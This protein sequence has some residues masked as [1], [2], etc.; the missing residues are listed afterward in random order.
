MATNNGI[1]IVYT[2]ITTTNVSTQAS[3][4]LL[5]TRHTEDTEGQALAK[6]D[7]QMQQNSKRSNVLNLP[8]TAAHGW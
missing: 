5:S 8:A 1:H 4:D 7:E 6:G 2:N 3:R